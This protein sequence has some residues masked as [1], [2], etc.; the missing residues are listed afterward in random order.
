MTDRTIFNRTYT[1]FTPQGTSVYLVN[2]GLKAT[3]SGFNPTID[4]IAG[5]NLQQGQALYVSGVVLPGDTVE[6]QVFR[7]SAAATEAIYMANVIGFADS[8][9]VQ[10]Q[11][12]TVDVDG[13]VTVPANKITGETSL[14]PG[15]YYFL[16]EYLG[17]ITRYATTSGNI[18]RPDYQASAP[19]G[20]AVTTTALTIEIGAPTF[21][22]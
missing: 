22:V 9:A 13:V 10:G 5:E 2:G 7:A 15:R 16:S 8:D 18:E 19:L 12:C 21:L 20:V 17:E 14:A 11:P 6:P 4:I 1:Q 3:A